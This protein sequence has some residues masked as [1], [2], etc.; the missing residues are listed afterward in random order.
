MA[1]TFF[2]IYNEKSTMTTPEF[3]LK[4]ISSL[5]L[6]N[7]LEVTLCLKVTFTNPICST[8]HQMVSVKTS[9]GHFGRCRLP[10][11]H[12][13]IYNTFIKLRYQLTFLINMNLKKDVLLI[14]HYQSIITEMSSIRRKL[15]AAITFG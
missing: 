14:F 9:T 13:D 5:I 15:C 10:D 1:L 3:I 12:S 4:T 7:Q 11:I 2:S 8:V 6:S